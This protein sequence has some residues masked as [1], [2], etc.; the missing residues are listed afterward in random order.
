MIPPMPKPLQESI[1][2]IL[3]AAPLRS[4]CPDGHFSQD[5]DAHTS[6]NFS[7]CAII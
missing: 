5:N 6:G 1:L 2:P 4:S 3:H 7:K